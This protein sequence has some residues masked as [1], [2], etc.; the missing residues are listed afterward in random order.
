MKKLARQFAISDIHGCVRTLKKLVLDE[1]KLSKADTLYLLGDYINKGPDSKGVIDFIF[2]L[3]N[4]GF[5]LYCLRGNHEQ[6]LIDG[7]IYSWEEIAFLSRGGRETLSSFGVDAIGDIP[8]KYLDFIKS[9]PFYIELEKYILIH[10]GLNFDLTDPYKD[11]F[12][13]LNIRKMQVDLEKTGG[14]NIIHGH[15]PMTYQD[16]KGDLDF[17]KHHI[18]IDA[19]CV[20]DHIHALNH[21]VALEIQSGKLYIQHNIE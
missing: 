6:Y 5:N 14:K 20:Y 12:S 21:L 7:L 18:S 13:M 10:A 1:I 15:V 11:D 17:K 2:Q 4:K 9:L 3:K 8:N 16:I 19:G